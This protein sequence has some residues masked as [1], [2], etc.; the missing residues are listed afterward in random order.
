MFNSLS[1]IL[2]QQAPI[3]T[4]KVRG[5]PSALMKTRDYWRKEA[6]KSIDPMAWTAYRNLIQEVNRQ[7]KITERE[8]YT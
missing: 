2:D 8:F 5:K 3:R 6:R 4:F 1:S 7:I